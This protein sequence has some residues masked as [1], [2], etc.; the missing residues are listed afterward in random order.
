MTRFQTQA[1]LVLLATLLT[2]STTRSANAADPIR[3]GTMTVQRHGDHGTPLILIPGLASGGWVWDDAVAA[4]K[5]DHVLYVVTLAG[6]DGIPPAQGKLMDLAND[7]LL[8]LIRTQHLDHPVL[9]GHSLG[10]TLSIQFAENHSDLISGVIAIDGLPVFPGTEQVPA[11]QRAMMADG[12][13]K[14]MAGATT[15]QFAAQQLQFMK[16]IGVLAEARA[17]ELAS[18]T[19][20][21]DPA[22]TAQYMSEDIALDL[23]SGLASITVPVLEICPYNAADFPPAHLMTEPQKTAY[24]R[25]LLQGTPRLEV[26]SIA[27]SRHFVMIDQPAALANALTRFLNALPATTAAIPTT[28]RQK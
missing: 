9:I 5:N 27:P 2:L 21:S 23:R 16:T 6:F 18:K 10:G 8:E 7:S 20:R 4:L 14:R 25:T 24:Y 12:I 13:R 3:V 28:R 19:S 11:Q 26:V 22:A 1:V 15:Q 17:I